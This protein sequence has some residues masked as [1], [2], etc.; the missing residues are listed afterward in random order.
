M[1]QL[2]KLLQVHDRNA[3]GLKVE[4]IMHACIGFFCWQR[5]KLTELD[6]TEVEGSLP[7]G[8]LY[9]TAIDLSFLSK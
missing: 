2:V 3:A 4:E 5:T 9:N 7:M 8:F 6:L 1:I